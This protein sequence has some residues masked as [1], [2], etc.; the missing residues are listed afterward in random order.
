MK[1]PPSNDQQ[2]ISYLH[3]RMLIGMCGIVLPLSCMFYAFVLGHELQDSVSDFYYTDVRNIFVGILFV[4]GFFLLTYKGYE[5][6]DSRFA[7]AGFYFA[8]GVAL[9]PC[10]GDYGYIHFISAFLLFSVF[11]FF[12]LRLFTLSVEKRGH[13]PEVDKRNRVYIACG[14]IMVACIV[15]IGTTFAISGLKEIRLS[16]NTTFWFETI[17]LISFAVSWLTKGR[18]YNEAKKTVKKVIK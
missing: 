9:F 7:N 4:L 3:L 14:W 5:P 17:A 10:K 15:L 16:Y 2:I 8:L 18:F 6:I 13:T 1:N 11:I 12:S